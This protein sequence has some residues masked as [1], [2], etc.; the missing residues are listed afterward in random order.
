[1]GLLST[2]TY[3]WGQQ[4]KKYFGE[5]LGTFYVHTPN[6]LML[7]P[8]I[9]SSFLVE[10]PSFWLIYLG[11]T[12]CLD[13]MAFITVYSLHKA[14]VYAICIF[15]ADALFNR[16]FPSWGGYHRRTVFKQWVI[17]T[18]GLLVGFFLQRTMVKSLIILYAPDII[19]Y[20]TA[21]P[22]KRL[23]AA[24]LLAFLLPYWFFVVFVTLW[25]TASKQRNE[26]KKDSRAA[27]LRANIVKISAG[28]TAGDPPNGCLFLKG[29]NGSGRIDLKKITHITV[30]DHYCRI[31]YAV[32]R[33]LKFETVRLSLKEILPQLPREYFLQIHRSHVVN[34]G[35]IERL[36]KKGRD[37]NVVLQRTHLELPVSRSRF[38]ELPPRLKAISA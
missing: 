29:E 2:H 19:S 7:Y 14:V 12:F 20:F 30:E 24:T 11:D 15:G 25:I 6:R 36:A 8:F 32:G 10:C 33:R 17:W 26:Q 1:M 16:L 4:I 34:V 9:F 13:N 28:S 38:K 18:L 27:R 31:N 5:D 3:G 23:S 22:E 35:H 21:H 37:H